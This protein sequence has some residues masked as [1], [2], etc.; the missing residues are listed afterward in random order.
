[1]S[2][3]GAG[4]RGGPAVSMSIAV[5]RMGLMRIRRVHV[6]GAGPFVGGG[7]GR[8]M[9]RVPGGCRRLG[10]GVWFGRPRSGRSLPGSFWRRARGGC[11]QP[12]PSIPPKTDG[13]GPWSKRAAGPGAAPARDRGVLAKGS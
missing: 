13:K 8:G 6:V 1:M 10:P 3:A 5:D 11:S 2:S 12:S 9:E 7:G 4:L